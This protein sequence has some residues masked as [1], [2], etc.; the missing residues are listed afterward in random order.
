MDAHSLKTSAPSAETLD[1]LAAVVGEE[2]AI[3]EPDDMENYVTEWRERWPGAA[4][5]VVRPASTAEVSEILKIANETGTAV[6]PQGG[7]TGAVGAQSRRQR[8]RVVL[9]LS[10]MNKF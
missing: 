7:N 3:R 4:A 6:V 9:S 10:R 1:R 8:A 2:Y 5:M